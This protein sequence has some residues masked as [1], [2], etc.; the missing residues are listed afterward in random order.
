MVS[1]P[2]SMREAPGS[3]PGV[4]IFPNL[5]SPCFELSLCL[6]IN[7]SLSLYRLSSVYPSLSLCVSVSISLSLSL[8]LSLSLY[9]ASCSHFFFLFLCAFSF[10]QRVVQF[11]VTFMDVVQPAIAQLVEHLTVECCSNQMVPGSIP[12]GRIYRTLSYR[13]NQCAPLP[14]SL[15]ITSNRVVFVDAGYKRAGQ[16]CQWVM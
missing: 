13:A 1:H 16:F 6:Y 14:T 5:S 7:V 4:S 3:I 15:H 10:E 2:L 9:A 12:G 8:F 11:Q